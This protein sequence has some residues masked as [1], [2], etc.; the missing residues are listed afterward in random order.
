[1][2]LCVHV[3]FAKSI[4]FIC[5]VESREHRSVDALNM[6]RTGANAL[7]IGTKMMET[8]FDSFKKIYLNRRHC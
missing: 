3:A 1:M 4:A 7:L 5:A 2:S 6:M 8:H